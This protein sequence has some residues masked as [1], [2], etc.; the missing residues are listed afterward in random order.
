MLAKCFLFN[1]NQIWGH[2]S[3]DVVSMIRDQ[4]IVHIN[5][6]KLHVGWSSDLLGETTGSRTKQR[7]GE[8]KRLNV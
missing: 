8:L 1:L 3:I 2:C 7:I 4:K 6:V 5:E